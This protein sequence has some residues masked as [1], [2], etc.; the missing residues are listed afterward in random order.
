MDL[1][2]NP[3]DGIGLFDR[4]DRFENTDDSDSED[5]FYDSQEFFD[6]CRHY[7][8]QAETE[9]EETVKT[10]SDNTTNK[11]ATDSSSLQP[12]PAESILSQKKE[13]D[14]SNESASPQVLDP[15][16]PEPS[17]DNTAKKVAADSSSLQPSPDESILS[18]RRKL[19]FS[20]ES[21][22]PQALEADITKKKVKFGDT[23]TLGTINNLQSTS[24][25]LK[26]VPS[27]GFFASK[28]LSSFASV[29]ANNNTS[30]A[31]LLSEKRKHDAITEQDEPS[32]S[33]MQKKVKIFEGNKTIMH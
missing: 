20:D 31:S 24:C 10:S 25:N 1:F 2:T 19:D 28:A 11:A 12:S 22:S 7:Y 5:T 4:A 15:A 3:K 13:C 29:F 27:S 16:T 9:I 14:S 33:R 26:T 21:A 6:E 30:F 23:S 8:D 32:V 17:S 18:Q